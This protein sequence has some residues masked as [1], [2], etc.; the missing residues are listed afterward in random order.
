MVRRFGPYLTI[1]P[2]VVGFV[3]LALMLATIFWLNARTQSLFDD[4]VALRAV[5]S[6][7]V[8][9]RNA[10]Q[11]AES[12]Q[13]GYLY[14]K[15]EVYLAPFH[16]AETQAFRQMKLLGAGISMFPELQGAFQKLGEVV[17]RK[18]LEMDQTLALQQAR[19]DF[20]ALAIVK[21]D[22]GKALMDEAGV[23]LNGIVRATD[24][25]LLD[26]VSEQQ[27]KAAQLKLVSLLSALVI[28]LVVAVV[29][30]ILT[31]YTRGLT[32]AQLKV[33]DLNSHLEERVRQ[34]T[35]DLGRANEM[36]QDA[37]NRAEALL[38]EVNHRVANSLTMVS[39]LV[40]MQA[41]SVKDAAAKSA[42]A[43]TRARIYAVALVHRELYTTGDVRFVLLND[44]LGSLLAHLQ[45]S[46]QDEMREIRLNIQ[47]A[48]VKLPIDQS[49]SLGVVVNEW[50]TN[51]LKYAYPEGKEEIR[52]ELR[53][54][55]DDRAE[56]TVADDG[57]GTDLSNKSKGTGF[58]SK[59]LGAMAQTLAAEMKYEAGSPG[60][61][62]RMTFPLPTV[63]LS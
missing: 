47:I 25:R 51:A 29:A 40:N 50:V 53:Q 58:G 19:R 23:Y 28:I 61:T 54:L 43:E 62:A 38:M 60:T 6:A 52:I 34:R 1:F 27:T 46:I 5:R 39:A 4:V 16:V 37:R 20:E 13:R 57:V 45:T 56:L 15:N 31:K 11:T 22:Q 10:L 48:P 32:S 9:L 12:S 21:T 44:Y 49:I 30:H 24:Q 42:L 63:G 18:I 8:D 59:I 41:N 36:L 55:G 3:A 2:V 33:A 14:T 7:A 35:N 17:S 26:R